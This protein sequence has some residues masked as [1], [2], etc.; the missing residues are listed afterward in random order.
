ME[1]QALSEARGAKAV[2]E[3]TAGLTAPCRRL[4]AG[5]WQRLAAAAGREL[6]VSRLCLSKA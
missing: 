4:P 6:C 3:P 5:L 1:A 2:A